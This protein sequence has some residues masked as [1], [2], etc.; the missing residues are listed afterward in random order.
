LKIE[1][2][3]IYSINDNI[4]DSLHQQKTSVEKYVV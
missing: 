2:I 4:G 1:V 3:V